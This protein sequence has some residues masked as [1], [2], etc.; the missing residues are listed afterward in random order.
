MWLGNKKWKGGRNGTVYNFN[1]PKY[2]TC[3]YS[4][5]WVP[6]I[7]KPDSFA[8]GVYTDRTHADAEFEERWGDSWSVQVGGDQVMHQTMV[9]KT[10]LPMRNCGPTRVSGAPEPF[11]THHHSV[12]QGYE[13]EE[14]AWEEYFNLDISNCTSSTVDHM[15][16]FV[17]VT[18]DLFKSEDNQDSSVFTQ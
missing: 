15:T 3:T 1:G 4:E 17:H 18:P 2:D 10:G 7:T 9:V 13:Y 14:S 5:A 11:C 12:K 6:S 16:A 8:V